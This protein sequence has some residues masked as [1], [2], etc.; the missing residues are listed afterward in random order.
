MSNTQS[1]FD[2]IRAYH[3]EEIPAVV[4][5]IAADPLLIPAAQF[6][7]PNLDIEQVRTLIR[8]CSTSDDIQR[9]IMYPAIG[10]IIHQTMRRFTS[11]GSDRVPATNG[12]LFV[13]NHR[14]ITLDA[15]LMQ[16]ALFENGLPTTDISLGDNLLHTPLVFELCK[17]NYMIK[18]IRKDDVTMREFL[19]NSRHL[20]EYIRY[21]IK[22]NGRSVW[23][24]QRNGRTK[25]GID[26]TEPGI[27]KMFSMSGSEDFVESFSQL[28]LAP[29]AIS[30]QYEPCDVLKAVELCRRQS[31]APYHKAEN[32]DFLSIL[33]GIKAYKGDANLTFCEPITTAEIEQVA[34]LP[35]AEQC[36]AL[37]EIMDRR[38]ISEY[39]LY[40]TNYLAYDILHNTRRFEKYYSAAA[41]QK[42]SLHLVRSNAQFE[43]MGVDK[44][45]AR[46][47]LLGIYA[48]PVEAKLNLGIVL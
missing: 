35:R 42:F 1:F 37:A 21:R 19:E 7:F 32:E 18:V 17:A 2:D 26:I 38:I 6:V 20:S 11:S 44:D 39:K 8:S 47:I 25:D 36:K 14:D 10:G 28:H 29:V 4:E 45:A 33:T 46:E 3:D 13:S 48:N 16:Y 31:G 24:A 34:Q 23:I 12:W 22:D 15:M 27:L 41:E 9:K 5:R 40:D 43:L 30:Y